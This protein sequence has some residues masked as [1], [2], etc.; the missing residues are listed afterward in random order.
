MAELSSIGFKETFVASGDLSNNQYQFVRLLDGNVYLADSGFADGVLQNKPKH[1]EPATV[2]VMGP[3]KILL[4]NSYGAGCMIGCNSGGW[5]QSAQAG[6]PNNE[7]RKYGTLLV[8]T[9]SGGIGV[10]NFTQV[11]S[12]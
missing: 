10:L 5:A 7:G 1:Q 11:G 3:T 2:V 12:T 4:N 6:S 8:G 9:T